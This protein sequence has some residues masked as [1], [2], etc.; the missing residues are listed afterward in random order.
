MNIID[1]KKVDKILNIIKEFKEF[2]DYFDM[3]Y[4]FIENYQKEQKTNALEKIQKIAKE[5]DEK[6]EETAGVLNTM[7]RKGINISEDKIYLDGYIPVEVEENSGFGSYG[8]YSYDRNAEYI[9]FD[10][11]EVPNQFRLG[12]PIVND[13]NPATLELVNQYLSEV[14]ESNKLSV[15]FKKLI[16]KYKEHK[17]EEIDYDQINDKL[18]ENNN[19]NVPKINKALSKIYIDLHDNMPIEMKTG[20]YDFK[21]IM[22]IDYLLYLKEKNLKKEIADMLKE[23]DEEKPIENKFLF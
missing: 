3:M 6:I 2:V 22:I 16:E 9:D 23:D 5:L 18:D 10:D 4:D 17:I 7:Y 13:N 19:I 14:K 21:D 20:P 11:R 8:K 15:E 1:M 12:F